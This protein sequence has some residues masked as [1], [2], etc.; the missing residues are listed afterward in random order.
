MI[1]ATLTTGEAT[2][3]EIAARRDMERKRFI[4]WQTYLAA[5]NLYMGMLGKPTLFDEDETDAQY[6]TCRNLEDAH[7]ALDAEYGR[8][9]LND[10]TEKN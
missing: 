1:T 3:A 7:T 4:L 8:L 10:G 5:S 6:E 2:I 9:Y